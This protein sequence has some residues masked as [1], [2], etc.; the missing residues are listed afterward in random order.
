[1]TASV[2]SGLR[3][4][5]PIALA[6]FILTIPA[7]AESPEIGAWGFDTAGKD[8]VVRPGDDFFRYSGGG[9][10]KHA[11]RYPLRNSRPIHSPNP[12]VP[13]RPRTP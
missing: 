6:S 13:E 2:R 9:W 3:A 7:S 8:T 11:N 5:F 1:M 12:H 4:G 10:T